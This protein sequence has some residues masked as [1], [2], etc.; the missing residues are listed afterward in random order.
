M[1][2]KLSKLRRWQ[3]KVGVKRDAAAARAGKKPGDLTAWDRMF[4]KAKPKR[5]T[6]STRRT[7]AYAKSKPR[8]R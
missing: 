6:A 8:Y 5:A 7:Q 4:A 3:I 2:K 1:P